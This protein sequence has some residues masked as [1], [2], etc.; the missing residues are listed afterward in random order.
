MR[1]QRGIAISAAAALAALTLAAAGCGGS[2]SS[3]TN[4][5]SAGAGVDTSDIGSTTA[6]TTAPAGARVNV[7]MGAPKEFSM[8]P[9]P[10]S[11]AAGP[12]TF[13]V[14][15]R[16]GLVHEMVVVP[17]PGGPT[18]LKKPDGTA[19]EAGSPGEAADVAPGSTKTFTVTLPA[20]KYVLLCNLPGHY[21]GGMYASFVVR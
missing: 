3:K 2:S 21:A 6:A 7:T 1:H 15:N 19:S 20:G 14:T 4:S 16:G 9:A 17:A 5:T 18:S 13:V 11:V 8:V 12:T 10:T